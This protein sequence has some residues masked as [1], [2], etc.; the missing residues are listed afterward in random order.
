MRKYFKK[1]L[2]KKIMLGIMAFAIPVGL[3]ADPV[4]KII[5]GSLGI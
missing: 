2:L 5:Q 1:N 3:L 4:S